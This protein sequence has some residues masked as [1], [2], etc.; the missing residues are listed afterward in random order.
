[1]NSGMKERAKLTGK[2][3]KRKQEG[4]H[5]GLCPGVPL[6]F[7]PWWVTRDSQRLHE[8]RPNI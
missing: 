3:V 8:V 2:A 1:M 7:P 4:A 5:P 6:S